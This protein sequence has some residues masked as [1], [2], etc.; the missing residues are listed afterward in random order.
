MQKRAK[1]KAPAPQIPME[2][3]AEKALE[4]IYV[5]CFGQD[6]ME[7]EDVKLLCKMLNAI[8]PS[9]GRQAVEKIVTSMAKQVA[10]GERKGPGVKTV[11]KEAAQRQLKDLEFLKQNKLDSV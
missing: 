2:A 1:L 4:A 11:S 7:D 10:A 9:V 5:C 6:M 3:R 8:F